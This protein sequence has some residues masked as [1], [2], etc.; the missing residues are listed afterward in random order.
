MSIVLIDA[1]I[2]VYEACHRNQTDIDW[3]GEGKT[4]YANFEA[5]TEDFAASVAAIGK[6]T[7][8]DDGVL[9]LTDSD[10]DANFRRKVWPEYKKHRG[11]SNTSRPILFAA[12][13]EWIHENYATKEKPGIEGDDTI[14]IMATGDI[15]GLP[16]DKQARVIASID[17]D[18]L[19]IPGRHYNWRKPGGV[20]TVTEDEAYYNLLYQTIIG[21]STDNFPGL[22]GCGPVGAGRILDD[23]SGQSMREMWEHVVIAFEERGL[24]RNDALTQARCARILQASDWDFKHDKVILWTPPEEER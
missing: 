10:R 23:A 7:G 11:D 13:R 19:T 22:P 12:L 16:E 17:K 20:F 4:G 21:D 3:D 24:S 6:A 1:D 8:C 15:N 14:G 18:M 9:I 5:A 2:I